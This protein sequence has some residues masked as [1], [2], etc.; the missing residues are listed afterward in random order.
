MSLLGGLEIQQYTANIDSLETALLNDEDLLKTEDDNGTW[1]NEDVTEQTNDNKCKRELLHLVQHTG[2]YNFDE[3]LQ[4]NDEH[5]KKLGDVTK[6][7][8]T[9]REI[10]DMQAQMLS[11]AKRAKRPHT[12][13]PATEKVNLK[14]PR[15]QVDIHALPEVDNN[16]NMHH[17]LP[18]SC[19]SN[20]PQ[21]E[22][23]SI[24]NKMGIKN[25]IKQERAVRLVGE[26]FILGIDDQL[27]LYV[28][29]VGGSGKSYVI[30]A[31]GIQYML[32]PFYQRASGNPNK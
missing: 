13:E 11:I 25:N 22:L 5:P 17:I 30:E 19:H 20:N 31:I 2:L 7:T 9:D 4:V 18:W 23:E 3:Q 8:D 27:L 16:V 21:D 26:H 15:T 24:I 32:L 14:C 12:M 29:G 10:L 1:I 28:V 6:L